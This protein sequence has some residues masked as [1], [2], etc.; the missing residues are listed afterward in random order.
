MA[1]IGT[2]IGSRVWK[3]P[4]QYPWPA[5]A[6]T[7]ANEPCNV[8]IDNHNQEYFQKD[9]FT[10]GFAPD[11]PWL[12]KQDHPFVRAFLIAQDKLV[13]GTLTPNEFQKITKNS[14]VFRFHKGPD[15][16][17]YPTMSKSKYKLYEDFRIKKGDVNFEALKPLQTLCNTY[18][19]SEN[20]DL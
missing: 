4:G 17:I 9:V 14:P 19:H 20:P 8:L 11:I 7:T 12:M 13:G 5:A 3:K 16:F 10:K 15:L 2:I 18:A 1:L 6:D